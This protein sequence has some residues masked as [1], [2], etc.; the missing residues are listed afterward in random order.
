MFLHKNKFKK[1]YLYLV[2]D[3]PE[4]DFLYDLVKKLGIENHVLFMGEQQDVYKF[5]NCFDC[6]VLPSQSEGLSIAL[7][8]AM[9]FGLPIVTTGINKKHDV[10]TDGVNGFVVSCGDKKMLCN[11]FEMLDMNKALRF[12]MSRENLVLVE[13]KFNIRRVA[14]EYIKLYTR[15]IN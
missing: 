14:N 9:S 15:L 7:L 5:Y 13:E 2:G 6:F 4:K 11:A 12:S 10:V 8:E 3:G 1:S